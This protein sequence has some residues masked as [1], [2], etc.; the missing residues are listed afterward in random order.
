MKTFRFTFAMIAI[1]MLITLSA[2]NAKADQ[3]DKRTLL[4]FAQ[5][6]E[7]PGL[8]LDAGTYAFSRVGDNPNVVRISSPDGSHVYATLLT[9]SDYRLDPAGETIVTFA[10]RPNGNPK[11]IKSWFYPGD[12]T[13]EEFIYRPSSEDNR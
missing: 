2:V 9:I 10:E 4:T 6:V 8:V 13:G 3:F 5:P 1:A 11:A 7:V 12:N